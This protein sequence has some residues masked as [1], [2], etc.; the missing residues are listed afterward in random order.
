MQTTIAGLI[1]LAILSLYTF[2]TFGIPVPIK[3]TVNI[4][5]ASGVA[6]VPTYFWKATVLTLIPQ[7]I[8]VGIIF[9]AMLWG[10]QEI[11]NDDRIRLASMH[12]KLRWLKPG[13]K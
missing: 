2:K 8:V 13:Q 10:L 4:L 5:I 1:G 9:V 6:I 7:Y 3:S 11:S 12:P